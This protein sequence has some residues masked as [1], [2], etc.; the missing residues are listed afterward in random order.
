M[1]KRF[2]KFSKRYKKLIVL[3]MTSLMVVV[4]ISWITRAIAYDVYGKGYSDEH[5]HSNEMTMPSTIGEVVAADEL[6]CDAL[7]VKADSGIQIEKIGESTD[8][9]G[10]PYTMWF[11]V[12][13]ASFVTP[14]TVMFGDKCGMA[15][16]PGVNEYM[17]ERVPLDVSRQLTLQFYEA[18]ATAQGGLDEYREHIQSTFSNPESLDQGS[19]LADNSE[20]GSGAIITSL[21][22]WA[23]DQLDI[24]LPEGTYT[25]I[26]ID[27]R[28]QYE[29]DP[30]EGNE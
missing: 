26:D 19:G 12:D 7:K 30:S 14:V 1:K 4:S 15:F 22:K 13:Q 28:W 25:I 8:S 6:K 10:F 27:D 21:D 29:Y 18:I 11:Y 2:T 24:A 9:R 23:L 17:T 20:A 5:D 16:M 3:A